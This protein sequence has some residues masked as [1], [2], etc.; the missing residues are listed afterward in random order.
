MRVITV[1]LACLLHASLAVAQFNT[2]EIGGIVRDSS[3][4]VL[5]G[6]TVTATHP[7]SGTVVERVTNE[8]GRYFLPALRVGRWEVASALSG[9]APQ[10]Q[11]L[12]LEVGRVLTLDFTLAVQ[13]VTAAVV[14]DARAPLLQTG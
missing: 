14:V 13:G 5:A 1:F 7:A 6:V 3:G 10:R 2:G 4:G 9:F 12:V 8:E 11:A